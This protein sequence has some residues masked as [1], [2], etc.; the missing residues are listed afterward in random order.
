MSHLTTIAARAADL[1]DQFGV[2][3]EEPLARWQRA[4]GFEGGLNAAAWLSVAFLF[5]RA[6]RDPR[7]VTL[8][9]S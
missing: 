1:A 3:I 6:I 8:K 7:P 2:D 5:A 4:G 9:D